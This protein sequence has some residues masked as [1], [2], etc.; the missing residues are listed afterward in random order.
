MSSSTRVLVGLTRALLSSVDLL[1]LA[2]TL[3]NLTTKDRRRILNILKE[4]ITRRGM[5]FNIGPSSSL[6][7]RFCCLVL[8]WLAHCCLSLLLFACWLSLLHSSAAL[9]MLSRTLLFFHC[10]S[11]HAGFHCCSFTA[12]LSTCWLSLLFFHCWFQPRP[13]VSYS[14]VS[15]H[16]VLLLLFPTC[17]L[18]YSAVCIVTDSDSLG[19][20]RLSFSLRI[21]K[22]LKIWLIM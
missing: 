8:C 20:R 17:C 2:N 3:D 21:T 7:T 4:M 14:A 9:S 16:A 1:L 10:C 22:T 5:D 15:L 19:N 11:L 18:V 13:A 6:A 12:V